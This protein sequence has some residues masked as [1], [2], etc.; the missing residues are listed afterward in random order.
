M[1][2]MLSNKI[3]TLTGTVVQ[4]FNYSRKNFCVSSLKVALLLL[5]MHVRQ[6]QTGLDLKKVDTVTTF[7]G[8]LDIHQDAT[9]TPSTHTKIMSILELEELSSR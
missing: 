8:A 9:L 6:L 4:T 1:V 7:K 5:R 2:I 3:P